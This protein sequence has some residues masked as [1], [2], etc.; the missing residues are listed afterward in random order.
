MDAEG[1]VALGLCVGTQPGTGAAR[2]QRA[3]SLLPG[4]GAAS[5]RA[6]WVCSREGGLLCPCFTAISRRTFLPRP[7]PLL[8]LWR[9]VSIRAPPHPENSVAYIELSLKEK[10]NSRQTEGA[11][12][13]GGG[14]AGGESAQRKRPC[15]LS[16]PW[17]GNTRPPLSP[18]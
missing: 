15:P 10:E 18:V 12:Y 2:E 9:W 3:L 8:D 14:G 7:S 11:V 16:P 5:L 4:E 13:R 1:K 17:K 6:P